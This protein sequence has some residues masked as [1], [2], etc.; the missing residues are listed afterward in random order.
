MFPTRCSS[1]QKAFDHVASSIDSIYGELTKD[2][3]LAVGGTA[4]LCLENADEPY[5]EGIRFNAMPPLKRFR[6]MDQLSG[7]EKSVAALALLFAIQRCACKLPAHI[8]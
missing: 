2:T 1:F 3:R 6:D 7:G 5:L 4:Y 8:I